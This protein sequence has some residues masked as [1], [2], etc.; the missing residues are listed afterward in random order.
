MKFA[1]PL[2]L[3]YGLGAGQYALQFKAGDPRLYS[4]TL[5]SYSTGAPTT[6]G[7]DYGGGGTGLDYGGPGTG[8]DYGGGNLAVLNPVNAGGIDAPFVVTFHG[9]G[10]NPQIVDQTLNKTLAFNITLGANDILVVDTLAHTVT[11]NGISNE[12]SSFTSTSS[13]FN[14]GIGTSQLQFL[15]DSSGS[16]TLCTVAF[17]DTWI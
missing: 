2:D 8:L 9:P 14:L 4:D 15:I 13:W 17:R 3:M 5:K 6:S 11:L 1:L 16:G 10:I 12:Y 7:L